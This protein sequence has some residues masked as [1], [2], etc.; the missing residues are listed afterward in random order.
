MDSFGSQIFTVLWGMCN[1]GYM[2]IEHEVQ[3]PAKETAGA[4]PF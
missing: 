3:D 4:N 1:L 2:D